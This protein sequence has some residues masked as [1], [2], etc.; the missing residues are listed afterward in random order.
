MADLNTV[1]AELAAKVGTTVEYV[2]PR[3]VE[4]VRADSIASVVGAG[5][6]WFLLTLA[7][8]VAVFVAV[9]T[10]DEAIIVPTLVVGGLAWLFLSA[11]CVGQAVGD[12]PGIISPEGKLIHDITTQVRK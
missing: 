8:G 9:K 1:L 5:V 12:I 10:D 4:Y 3:A 2:W 7:F 11:I 6:F